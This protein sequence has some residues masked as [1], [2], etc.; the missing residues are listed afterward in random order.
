MKV[1]QSSMS[2]LGN[3]DITMDSIVDP[4][5]SHTGALPSKQSLENEH[6]RLRALQSYDL[7]DREANDSYERIASMAARY[8]RASVARIVLVDLDRCWTAASTD[9]NDSAPKEMPRKDSL[10]ERVVIEQ[11]PLVVV[12]DIEAYYC[13]QKQSP[14]SAGHVQGSTTTRDLERGE[15][16]RMFMKPY[17]ATTPENEMNFFAGA[18]LI[19][20]DGHTMGTLAVLDTKCRPQGIT[21]AQ[22]EVLMNMAFSIMEL[23]EE[24]RKQLLN[25]VNSQ[26]FQPSL[27]RSARFVVDQLDQLHSDAELLS[28]TRHD[29]ANA[30][31]S[32]LSTARFLQDALRQKDKQSKSPSSKR[33]S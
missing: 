21:S 17:L 23:M 3:S 33:L 15:F 10:Y 16:F 32:A 28:M 24:K 22:G 31:H 11:K 4:V 1:E 9:L 13:G 14:L 29:Q 8:L 2:F 12:S 30:I 20:A 25:G 19:S 5:A 18:A 27:L 26:S 7:L 6:R